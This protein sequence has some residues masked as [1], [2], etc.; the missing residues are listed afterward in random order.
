MFRGYK[1][2]ALSLV[3]DGGRY[4]EDACYVPQLGQEVDYT[5]EGI[6]DNQIYK[7]HYVLESGT[8][9]GKSIGPPPS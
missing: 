3:S 1:Y 5:T 4:V 7:M 2:H 6:H 8:V 9:N